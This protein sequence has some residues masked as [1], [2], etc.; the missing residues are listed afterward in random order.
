M[1]DKI[2][3]HRLDEHKFGFKKRK[4]KKNHSDANGCVIYMIHYVETSS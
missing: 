3:A 4:G 1:A 2:N